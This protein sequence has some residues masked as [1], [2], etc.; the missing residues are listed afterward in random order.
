MID[1]VAT[2]P[3]CGVSLGGHLYKVRFGRGDSGKS[4]G[5]RIIYLFARETL[6][7][8]LLAVFAK[9]ERAN[10][11]AAEFK[12]LAALAASIVEAYRKE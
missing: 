11:S 6:P 1:L 3:K 5:A 4:G 10:L 2:D 8:F 12:A 7:I 9:N